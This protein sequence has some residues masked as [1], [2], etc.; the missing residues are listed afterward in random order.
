MSAPE[1][2]WRD[3]RKSL[4]R[5]IDSTK[6]QEDKIVYTAYREN[7]SVEIIEPIDELFGKLITFC[8]ELQK[9]VINDTHSL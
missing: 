4:T 3:L 9:I 7:E 6:I 1:Q 5:V 2:S 8:N